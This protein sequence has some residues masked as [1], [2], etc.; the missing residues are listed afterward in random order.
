MLLLTTSFLGY[1]L[2]RSHRHGGF[3]KKKFPSTSYS[4]LFQIKAVAHMLCLFIWPSKQSYILYMHEKNVSIYSQAN[5]STNQPLNPASIYLSILV[6]LYI[7]TKYRSFLA[8]H[9]ST[10]FSSK[11]HM[12]MWWTSFEPR[13]SKV[14]I[15]PTNARLWLAA[16]HLNSWVGNKQKWKQRYTRLPFAQSFLKPLK[17]RKQEQHGTVLFCLKQSGT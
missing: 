7:T 11:S 8:I 9:L 15:N 4:F 6:D 2:P 13:R 17:S 5:I 1:P 14:L 10:W 12:N 3:E 16:T